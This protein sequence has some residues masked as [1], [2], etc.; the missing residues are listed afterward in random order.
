MSRRRIPLN[1]FGM[2]FGLAGLATSWRIAANLDLTP[3]WV[4]DVL[5][6]IATVVWAGSCV[7][8]LRY[9]VAT[10]GAWSRDL[11]DMTAGPFASLAVI[12]PILL[13]ADGIE[14]Y[15]PVVGAVVVDVFA[16]L[17]LVLGGWFTGFWMR[18]G[19]DF[20]RLHPGYFLPTVAGGLVASAGLA[21]VGQ[22]RFAQVML[23]LGLV[24]WAIMGSMILARLIF[25]PPLPDALAPTMAIEVAPAAVASLA[26]FFANGGRVDFFAAVLAGYGLLMVTAQLPLL[27]RYIRLSFSLGTWAFTFSWTA[28]AGAALFWIASTRF[29]GDRASSYLVLAAITGL[30]GGIAART[31]VAARRGRLL[32]AAAAASEPA[33]GGRSTNTS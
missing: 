20:S 2:G 10:P 17:V 29:V 6:A 32:P 9:A 23:G 28:V 31:V 24:C 26:H 5:A 15:A 25:R 4:S 19:T 7:V 8:Y 16:V 3:H 33:L 11:S 22:P 18:G 1:V 27:P 13:A 21:E 30:V 12:T 14:P